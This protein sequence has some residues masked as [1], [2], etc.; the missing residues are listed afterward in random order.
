[1]A[2]GLLS[3]KWRIFRSNLKLDLELIAMICKAAAR[4]HNYV[5]DN[6]RIKFGDGANSTEN[7]GVEKFF[8]SGVSTKNR[9]YLNTLPTQD[10]RGIVEKDGRRKEIL[11]DIITAQL[12][13]PIDNIVR[14]DELDASSDVEDNYEW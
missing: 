10:T 2:F 4:L 7:F 9:G 3:T 5:I 8:A 13:R 1:M 11:N 6:D 12:L 14:N